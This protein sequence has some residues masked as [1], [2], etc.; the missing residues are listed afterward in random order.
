MDPASVLLSPGQHSLSNGVAILLRAPRCHLRAPSATL[1]AVEH[2]VEYANLV[3]AR[4]RNGKVTGAQSDDWAHI[5]EYVSAI[6]FG[7]AQVHYR[8]VVDEPG[9][10]RRVARPVLHNGHAGAVPNCHRT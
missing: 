9:E 3:S 6:S 4:I 1:P 8:R 10:G 5:A 2:V 7:A